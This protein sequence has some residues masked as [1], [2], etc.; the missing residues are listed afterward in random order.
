MAYDRP[1]RM[2]RRHS[3]FRVGQ[4]AVWESIATG[5][6]VFQLW[7]MAEPSEIQLILRQHSSMLLMLKYLTCFQFL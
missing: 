1:L 4:A 3:G 5:N 2:L 6:C 7:L